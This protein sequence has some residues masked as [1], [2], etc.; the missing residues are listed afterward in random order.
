MTLKNLNVKSFNAG[1]FTVKTNDAVG[2]GIGN[3]QSGL[4]NPRRA[5]FDEQIFQMH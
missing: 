1:G 5:N 4:A 2:G 3:A